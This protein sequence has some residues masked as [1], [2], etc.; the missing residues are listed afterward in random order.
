MSDNASIC[1]K[2]NHPQATE[3]EKIKTKK[4]TNDSEANGQMEIVDKSK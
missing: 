1:I 4:K 3:I 2:L